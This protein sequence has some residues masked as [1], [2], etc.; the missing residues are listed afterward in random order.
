MFI[1]TWHATRIASINFRIRVRVVLPVPN[2]VLNVET[3]SER[4]GG[5]QSEPLVSLCG[6]GGLHKASL[7]IT[8]DSGLKHKGNTELGELLA[9]RSVNEHCSRRERLTHRL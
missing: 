1:I 7:L 2:C 4:D 6:R 5:G 3:L 8:A 9:V